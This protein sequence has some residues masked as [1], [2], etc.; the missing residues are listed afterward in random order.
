MS[1]IQ[2]YNPVSGHFDLVNTSSGGANTIWGYVANY[3]ALPLGVTPS[4]PAIGDLVGVNA[5]QG[6]WPINFRAEGFYKRSALTGVASTDY[7]TKPFAGFPTN[8]NN[9]DNLQGGTTDEYYHLTAI[10]HGYYDVTSS[11]QTQL[12]S[13]QTTADFLSL[14]VK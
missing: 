4:D 7:G 5:S 2:R 11:I 1:I 9:L 12:D 6:V 10:Q 13:K 8:H 14:K 3:S